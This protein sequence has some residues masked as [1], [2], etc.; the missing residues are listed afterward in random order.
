MRAM[1][2]TMTKPLR[3]KA[4]RGS[5]PVLR[6]G[7]GRGQVTTK[8]FRRKRFSLVAEG[9]TISNIVRIRRT[10]SDWRESFQRGNE[11]VF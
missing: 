9:T 1:A 3:D 8:D 6:R 10:S 5:A 2:E 11:R 4:G 7:Q